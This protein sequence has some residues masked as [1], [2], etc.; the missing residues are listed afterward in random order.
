MFLL[1]YVVFCFFVVCVEIDVTTFLTS[2]E[3]SFGN[4]FDCV[5][6]LNCMWQINQSLSISTINFI[7]IPKYTNFVGIRLILFLT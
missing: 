2:D 5:L 6:I 7:F 1:V 3:F 4:F